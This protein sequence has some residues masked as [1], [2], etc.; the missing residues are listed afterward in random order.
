M[1]IEFIPMTDKH[2][3]LVGLKME[4][5]LSPKK[6]LENRVFKKD[7]EEVAE[8]GEKSKF[9]SEFDDIFNADGP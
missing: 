8:G 2:H 6:T 1:I 4:K 7:V 9:F 3:L 5:V